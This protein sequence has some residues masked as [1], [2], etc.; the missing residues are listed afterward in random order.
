MTPL[1]TGL[2]VQAS[3]HGRF[4]NLDL[5]PFNRGDASYLYRQTT[6]QFASA[7]GLTGPGRWL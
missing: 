6:K 4:S 2:T 3:I 7:T 5:F 1:N